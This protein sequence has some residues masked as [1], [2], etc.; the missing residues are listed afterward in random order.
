[1]VSHARTEKAKPTC[2]WRDGGD[3]RDF[4]ILQ[5]AQAHRNAINRQVE[6]GAGFLMTSTFKTITRKVRMLKMPCNDNSIEGFVVMAMAEVDKHEAQLN[7]L[8]FAL[9]AVRRWK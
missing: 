8:L 1:M 3:R 4:Q 2:C 9:Q 6:H 7:A 5:P